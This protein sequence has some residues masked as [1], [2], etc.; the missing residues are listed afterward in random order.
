MIL[1][2]S[3]YRLALNGLSLTL[4]QHA[5]WA[6]ND[7]NG[8]SGSSGNGG[9][10]GNSGN[11]GNDGNSGNAGNSG[12]SNS[13]GNA[14]KGKSKSPKGTPPENAATTPEDAVTAVNPGN[15]PRL[16][17]NAATGDRIEVH[18]PSV[19]VVHSNG[20]SERI[21]GGHYEMRDARGRTII[22]RQATNSDR[23]RLLAMIE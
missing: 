20:L 5:A 19:G 2:V 13:S 14:G 11:S 23:A 22:R 15:K 21:D 7:G 9:N 6:K 4:S 8:S 12:K 17:I 3:P 1:V 16:Y 18:G 10:S